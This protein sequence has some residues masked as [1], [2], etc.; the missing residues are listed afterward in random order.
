M[1]AALLLI[2]LI[3]PA[4][5]HAN[6]ASESFIA[7]RAVRVVQVLNSADP[8]EKKR[9]ELSQLVDE[10]VDIEKVAYYTLGKYRATASEEELNQYISAFKGYLFAYYVKPAAGF[11][12]ITLKVTGSVD[13]P[14]GKGS[15]VHT[16]AKTPSSFE[17]DWYVIGD[18]SIVDVEIA[19][20]SAA[21]LLRA[22]VLAVL[23]LNGGKVSAATGLLETLVGKA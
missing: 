5:A 18:S 16:V 20:I 15:I 23:A 22:Q 17:L 14:D 13:L 11:S 6:Q 12:G 2:T 3:S 1:A 10:N 21:K 7:E 8:I 19:G 9:D 4:A